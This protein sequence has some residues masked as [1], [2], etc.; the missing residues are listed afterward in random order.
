MVKFTKCIC[1]TFP[2]CPVSISSVR[3]VSQMSV[4]T[5]SNERYGLMSPPRCLRK[6]SSRVWQSW[7][8]VLYP[9]LSTSSD[10]RLASRSTKAL[11]PS[12]NQVPTRYDL[13]NI[14]LSTASISTF[15]NSAI[16]FFL[17]SSNSHKVDN[18]NTDSHSS[19]FI[20]PRRNRPYL[21]R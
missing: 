8:A 6:V 11:Y 18:F 3:K 2:L 12:N 13:A 16:A 14:T 20:L 21:P 7:D 9:N 19:L 15:D 5:L 1:G 10:D 17:S 4:S